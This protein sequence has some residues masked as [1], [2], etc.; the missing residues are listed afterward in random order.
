[1]L[2]NNRL[3]VT[4]A[5]A[6]VLFA[7]GCGADTQG[8]TGPSPA[9]KSHFDQS[10]LAAGG[11]PETSR[12]VEEID[13]V[14]SE[15][16]PCAFAVAVKGE[17]TVVVQEFETHLLI[18]IQSQVTLT[19]LATGFS[20]S[21]N[22][23]ITRVVRFDPLGSLENVTVFGSVYRITLPG[24]GI[25]VQDTGV[26]TYDPVT[27]QVLFEGGPHE[28]FH[29]GEEVDYCALLAGSTA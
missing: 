8:V 26:I 21:D 25:I 13:F 17:Q 23:A 19:N 2:G 29:T 1:M 20:I 16:N 18:H 5:F 6:P 24:T 4:F 7:A 14:T 22:G 11:Q 3:L 28:V 9:A 10:G 27:N 12:F 15:G